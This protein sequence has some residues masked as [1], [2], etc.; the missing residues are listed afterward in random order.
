MRGCRIFLILIAAAFLAPLPAQACPM[1]SEFVSSATEAEETDN[2]PAAVNRT[3]YFMLGVP[4]TA[5]MVFSF[6]IWRGLVKNEAY[7]QALRDR[8]EQ[9]KSEQDAPKLNEPDTSGSDA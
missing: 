1:C 7:R 8:E 3:I 9:A 2:F 4:Y 6:L 5:F